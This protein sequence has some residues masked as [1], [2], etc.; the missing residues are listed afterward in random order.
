M[1]PRA[2]GLVLLLITAF[3]WGSNWPLLKML[4]TEMPPLAA[5]SYAGFLAA[6]LLA[7]VALAMRQSLAVPRAIWPRLC[8]FAVLNVTA[9]MGLSTIALLWL[10]AA[11]GAIIAYTMP[12]WAALLAWLM[13]KEPMGWAKVAALCL[14]GTGI[15]LL[16]AGQPF[17]IA[18][19]KYLG[20]AMIL[21]AAILFALGAVLAKG[22]PLPLPPLAVV[23]WQLLLGC[24]PLFIASLLVEEVA[25]GAISAR[26]W[27]SFL[28]MAV[29]S[30]A[31][32]YLTWFGALR[33]LPA[34]S[35]ALGTL[36]APVIGTLGAGL[37]L[38][39]AL[40][41]PQF[42]ALGCIVLAVLLAAR[43]APVAPRVA[44]P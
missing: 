16:F 23:T 1:T 15:V 4:L 10:D 27:A 9:W 43:S 8:L 25:L 40:G 39:E 35:A 18:A 11:E 2:A 7:L 32:S 31:I 44:A 24:A 26:G 19:D 3:G 6:A 5:R 33:R 38:E 41:W 42:A 36:L 29:M 28:W 30:L 12:V 34:S 20:A 13:L 14:G 21:T 37:L 22:G 17:D